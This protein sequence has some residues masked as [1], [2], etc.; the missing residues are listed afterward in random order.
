MLE[1]YALRMRPSR[2]GFQRRRFSSPMLPTHPGDSAAKMPP[3]SVSLL[4]RLL[5]FAVF[6]L[7]GL[8]L[9]RGTESLRFLSRFTP[10]PSAYFFPSSSYLPQSVRNLSFFPW[11]SLFF[12][13]L[14][15]LYLGSFVIFLVLL[16]RSFSCLHCRSWS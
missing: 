9:L 1:T 8:V 11:K 4:R 15:F 14:F 3:E 2:V 12:S 16:V 13:F 10:S 5:L 7:A 6:F